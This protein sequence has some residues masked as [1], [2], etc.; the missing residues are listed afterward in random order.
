MLYDASLWRPAVEAEA[1]AS[2][3]LTS[4]LKKKKKKAKTATTKKKKK[5]AG[6]KNK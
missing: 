5:A 6:A 1:H 4:A 3:D 2:D